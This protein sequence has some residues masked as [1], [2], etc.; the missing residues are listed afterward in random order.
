MVSMK[1]MKYVIA[2]LAVAG[3]YVSSRALE[4]H[5]LPPGAALPCAV[6]ARWDCGEVNHGNYSVFPPKSIDEYDE[7]GVYHPA[8]L[9]V[10]VALV[11]IIGYALIL[12]A[13]L[14]GRLRVVLELSRIGFFCAAFLSYIEAYIITKWCIYCVWSLGIITTILAL[15]IVSVLLRRRRRAESMVAV[16]TS[17]D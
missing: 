13:A 4:I 14:A 15:S 7:N 1:G 12:I 6:S 10:P 5:Y 16:L 9:H 11:G 2:V 8:K 3:L 17:E